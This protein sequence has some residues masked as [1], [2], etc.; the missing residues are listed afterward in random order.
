M[1]D[2]SRFR[3]MADLIWERSALTSRIAD[4]ASGRGRLQA[5]LYQ[6]GFRRVTSW[7]TR[8]RNFGPRRNYHG[9]LFDYRSAPRDYDLV[10]G[11]HPDAATDHIISYAI[12]HRVPFIVCPCCVLPSATKLADIGYLG[13]IRHLT[14]LAEAAR[15]TVEVTKLPMAGRNIVLL[16]AP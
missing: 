7:D 6:R 12:K 13:W 9:G 4:V 5:E 2:A 3:L 11:M 10:A 15:F 1:G 8:G 14:S 16:G